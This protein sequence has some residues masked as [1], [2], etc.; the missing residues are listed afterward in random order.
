ME[1]TPRYA[2]IHPV[3]GDHQHIVDTYVSTDDLEVVYCTVCG[4]E[5]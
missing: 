3:P 5:W 2:T 4:E 1:S